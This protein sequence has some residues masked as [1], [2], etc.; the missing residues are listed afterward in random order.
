MRVAD[1]MSARFVAFTGNNGCMAVIGNAVCT[2]IDGAQRG[3]RVVSFGVLSG[4]PCRTTA[5]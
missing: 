2:D 5:R 4:K 1:D 3:A